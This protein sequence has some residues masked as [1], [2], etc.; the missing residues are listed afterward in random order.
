MEGV[1][2]RADVRRQGVGAAM[3]AALERVIRSA[4]DLGSLGATDEA[5]AFYVGRGW[6]RWRGPASTLTPTGIVRTP[7]EDGAIYVLPGAAP[8]DLDAELVCDW[9]DG[10]VW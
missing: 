4:Y 8:L 9:R 6:E 5:V 1:G 3:M 2:V 10:D 7:D